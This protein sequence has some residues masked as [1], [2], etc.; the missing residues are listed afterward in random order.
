MPVQALFGLS[1]LLSFVASGTVAKLYIA[2]QLQAKRWE[3]ALLP[4]VIPHLFRF[5][6][7]SFLVSGVVYPSLSPAF[8]VPAAYGDLIATILAIIATVGLVARA[9]WATAVVWLF[10]VWGAGDLLYAFY[11]GFISFGD[12]P[13]VLGAAFFIPTL[14]VPPLLVSHALISWLLLRPKSSERASTSLLTHSGHGLTCISE[15]FAFTNPPRMPR[16]G[17]SGGQL[18]AISLAS[19]PGERPAPRPKE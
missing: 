5:V 18:G 8:A 6:G 1:V 2:P 4:L 15:N 12:D 16:G 3:D 11:A 7:L 13:G 17:S 14:L 9:Y 10:N 19:I